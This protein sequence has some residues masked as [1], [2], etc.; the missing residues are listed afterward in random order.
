LRWFRCHADQSASEEDD[1][2]RVP[3]P[4]ELEEARRRVL[5]ETSPLSAENVPLREALGRR[6]AAGVLSGEPVPAFDNSAMDGFALR[7]ADTQ[8]ANVAEPVAL[9]LVDE[10][11]A[12]SPA[13]RSPEL[14]EA[15][16]ISTGAAVPDGADAVLRV[17]N[18][19]VDDGRVLVGAVVAPGHDVRRAGEDLMAGAPV[20]AAGTRLGPAELG[21]LAATGHPEVSCHRR[22]RVSV[23]TSGDELIAPAESMR[24]GG[25]RNSN[26]YSVPA[27]AEMAGAEVSVAGPA[28][29]RAEATRE[30]IEPLLDAD[31]AVVCGGVSVGEHDHVKAA[32]AALGVEERFWGVALKPGK[33]TWF[34]TRGEALVFGLPGNPVSA[35]VTFLLAVRPALV[36]MGGGDPDSNRA[37]AALAEDYEKPP[38]RAHALRC[39]LELRADGCRAHPFPRQGSHVLTSM[40]G[41]DC[42][43]LLPA[44]AGSVRAGEPVEIELLVGWCGR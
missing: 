36:A 40:L 37:W 6:L 4:I 27:L 41:A 16:W 3:A 20:L 44:E 35:M 14:G 23:L 33:P 8:R 39:R 15:V 34:G 28:P 29:D 19:Q 43:A 38:G 13:Q 1:V 24:P 11:R 9:R 25:V 17:E 21:V 5:A 18:A 22:P 26:A 32:L 7:A 30:A 12:G 42:L 10:S 2:S 31:V